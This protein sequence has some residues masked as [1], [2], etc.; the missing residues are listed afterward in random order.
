MSDRRNDRMAM[1][2]PAVIAESIAL[3]MERDDTIVCIGEDIGKAGGVFGATAGLQER[4]GAD[5]VLDAPISEMA[6]TGMGVG[7]AQA[8]MRPLIEIMFVDFIG[9][10]LEQVY[11]AAA[12]IHY[13]SGGR[14]RM[15]IVFKTAG[16]NIG[17]AAQHSQCLWG[18]FA[19]LPGLKVVAPCNPH[20]HKGLMAAALRSDDPIVFIEHK[21]LLLQ[22]GRDF[23]HHPDIP[24]RAYTI[25]LGEAAVVRQGSDVTLA[26]LSATVE[27]ALEAAEIVA[28]EGISVE[29][30]DLRSVVPLDTPTVARSAARTGRL[31]VVDEDYLSYGLTAE[32]SMRV[33]EQIGLDGLR[34]IDRLALPDVPI[35]AALSLEQA[36]VPGTDAITAKLRAMAQG[37]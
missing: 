18:L 20:D 35:P 31:L 32:L 12:K 11:N 8:G 22:K 16:G 25:P 34:Q 14:Q 37:N 13:M 10:C 30:I 29:V 4:F 3:E 36:V 21:A 6:F 28:D 7:L 17:S 5:R 27:T 23:R 33:I 26:T 9:V 2:L 1:G 24:D 19:H 15:P